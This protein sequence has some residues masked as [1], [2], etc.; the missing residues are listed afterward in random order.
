MKKLILFVNIIIVLALGMTIQADAKR[1]TPALS[2]KSVSV[3]KGSSAKVSI[4]NVTPEKTKWM[5]NKAGKKIITLSK[6]KKKAVTIKGKKIGTATVT[7]KVTVKGKKVKPLK[8]KVRVTKKSNTT[9]VSKKTA[10]SGSVKVS[11]TEEGYVKLRYSKAAGART[12]LVQ[13]KNGKGAWK[14]LKTSSKTSITDKTVKEYT[15]YYYRVRANYNGSHTAYSTAVA[16]KTGKISGGGDNEEPIEPEEKTAKYTYELKTMNTADTTL[17][18]YVYVLIYVKTE[19]PDLLTIRLDS[20]E[21]SENGNFRYYIRRGYE[22]VH[23]IGTQNAVN[24]GYLYVCCWDTSGEK[25]LTIQEKV[26]E[27]WVSAA[28][29]KIHLEDYDKAEHEWARSVM[30]EV[31]DDTMTKVKKLE[32][33]Q[34]Y[35]RGNFKYLPNNGE[36]IIPLTVNVG[37]YWEKKYIDCFDAT[38]IMCLFAEELGLEGHWTY[39]GY[40]NHYYATVT[41]DGIDY[42]FDASPASATGLI[43]DWEYVL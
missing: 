31:T 29:M 27:K 40:L 24:G 32:Q 37:A 1:K 5:V 16:I 11:L 35:I 39:A 20:G 41:I 34:Y 4:K 13:R 23:Y 18:N 33:L 14:S 30:A 17:Y 6:K 19:N 3:K 25:N 43:T 22:D 42:D 21:E 12:Y 28:D 26:G 10:F 36:R 2:R 7:A 8:C 9:V 15:T 38:D